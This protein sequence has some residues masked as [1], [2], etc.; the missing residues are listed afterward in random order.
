MNAPMLPYT[1]I[2]KLYNRRRLGQRTG[3]SKQSKRRTVARA[4]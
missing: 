2:D 3:R 4:G 1:H